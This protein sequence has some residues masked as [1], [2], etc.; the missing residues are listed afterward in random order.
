MVRA[1]RLH[2]GCRGF[3]SLTAH[4]RPSVR[5]PHRPPPSP[6]PLTGLPPCQIPVWPAFAEI[7]GPPG[8]PQARF[9]PEPRS[10]RYKFMRAGAD[11][12]VRGWLTPVWPE[13][14]RKAGAGGRRGRPARSGTRGVPAPGAS[15]RKWCPGRDLNPDELP[16]TPLKRTRIPIP[17]PGHQVRCRL[18]SVD[19]L[20]GVEGIGTEDGT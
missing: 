7:E 10:R 4:H 19:Q 9:H 17:P 1:P 14:V 13:S 11:F 20:R 3:E 6:R 8:T 15:G 5:V 18:A 2:R 12:D 16:H